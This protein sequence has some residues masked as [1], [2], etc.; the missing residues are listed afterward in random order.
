MNIIENDDDVVNFETPTNSPR[1]E[2]VCPGA[3]KKM[4]KCAGCRVMI[5][6]GTGGENQQ[7]HMGPGGCLEEIFDDFVTRKLPIH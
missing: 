1:G 5:E 3:P 2:P 4:I 7:A 6:C